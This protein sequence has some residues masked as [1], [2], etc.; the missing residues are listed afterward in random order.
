MI[1]LKFIFFI[2]LFVINLN[3]ISAT[4]LKTLF[5]KG[6]FK[7]FSI[8]TQEEK[9]F[10][11]DNG[12]IKSRQFYI[13]NKK[14]GTWEFYFENGKLKSTIDFDFQ[15]KNEEAIVKNYDEN[16]LIVSMG[17][18]FNTEMVSDWRYYD[19]NGRI[20]HIYNHSTG[21]IIVFNEEE[22]PI[23]KLN[24][25]EFAEELK[26]VQKVINDDRTRSSEN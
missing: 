1:N 7:S 2:L 20:N 18:I 23:L 19:E 24:E 13:G 16:G 14:T 17:K 10:Y 21:E 3:S 22:K 25:K 15:S 6:K 8:A 4:N 11:F 26:K 12:N 5:D 9:K